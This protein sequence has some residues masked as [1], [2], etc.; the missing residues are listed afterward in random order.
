MSK[1]RVELLENALTREKL[2]R[3]AAEKILE[4]KSL[5]LYE[6]SEE[7]KKTNQVLENLVV[8]K[9]LE[10]KGVFKNIIDPYCVIDFSG[11]IIE[12]N[13]ATLNLLGCSNKNEELNVNDFLIINENEKIIEKFVEVRTTG[14]L[15][16]FKVKIKSRN[17]QIKE[18]NINASL[19]FNEKKEPVAVQGIARDITKENEAK[20]RL[21]ESENRLKDLILNLDNGIFL[22]DENRKVILVNEKLCDLFYMTDSP[23]SYIGQDMSNGA[24]EMKQLF[25]NPDKFVYR[26]KEIIARREIV[27]AEE[28]HLVDGK[29]LER[30]YLPI[31]K[32]GEFKGHLW[33]FNDVTLKRKFNQ[34]LEMQKQK[35]SN[36]IANMHLG[37]IEVNNEDEI[38]L[39][40]QSFEEMSGYSEK[41]LIGQQIINFFP[42]KPQAK[43]VVGEYNSYEINLK[44]KTKKE[45]FWLVGSA[46]N[47]N[48]NGQIIGSI[49]VCLDITSLKTL[50]KQKEVLLKEL[51]KSNDELQ[52]Y[53]HIVSHDLKSP[54]R[55]VYALV[56]WLKEDN[57]DKL[58]ANSI[59]NISLI[60]STLEKME[61]LISDILN[62]S[63][64]SIEKE[65][66]KEV[67]LNVVVDNIEQILLIPEHINLFRQNKLPVLRGDKTK[68]QQLF[69]NLI[70]N[71]IKFIDKKEGVVTLNV[72]DKGSF[73]QF[74]VQDNGIGIEKKYHNKIFKIF[75]SLN[76]SKDST[77]IGLSIVKKIVDLY[78]G[79]I[80]LK[81]KPNVGTTFYFTLRK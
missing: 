3:K 16:N 54:L 79:E 27:K 23:E 56:N 64:L 15:Q 75:N 71:A 35:Y 45:S 40:N 67:D 76:K 52:E 42:M 78:K 22:E 68:F 2:A 51:E 37:L 43:I 38:L 30:N 53:A 80:W 59:E 7:V 57:L 62:Y 50:E 36:I 70:S 6:L 77:G 21:I 33:S 39:V 41:E 31:Y 18:L 10:L 81:S 8:K 47:Y 66:Q 11:N 24:E 28:V 69:Q 73:Y 44:T 14:Q 12:M 19:I 1:T 32:N 72:E 26:Y 55:S 34:N 13:D 74:S 46:P 17:H 48:V 49:C 5:E 20:K 4:K 25:K 63:S 61:A 9:E 29:I 65:E 58:D 60:E